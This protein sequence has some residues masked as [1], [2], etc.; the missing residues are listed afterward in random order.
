MA[1]MT[2][3]LVDGPDP[4]IYENAVDAFAARAGI[5]IQDLPVEKTI[6]DI[7]I[8]VALRWWAP[9]PGVPRSQG[10]EDKVYR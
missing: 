10:K 2:T 8:P 9:S 3:I 4:S 5:G 1:T 7:Y 6:H